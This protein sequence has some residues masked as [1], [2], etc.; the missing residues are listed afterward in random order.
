QAWPIPPSIIALT[1]TTSHRLRALA[2]INKRLTE[3]VGPQPIFA[4][5]GSV[6]ARSPELR[7]RLSGVY[8][9]D[10]VVTAT[11]NVRELL[12]MDNYE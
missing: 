2:R 9:G 3:S 8:L 5:W 12:N 7:R 6:F 1:A 10:D 11:R 4:Y